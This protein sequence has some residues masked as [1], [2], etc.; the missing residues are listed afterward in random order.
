MKCRRSKNSPGAKLRG[1][2]AK[3]IRTAHPASR[4]HGGEAP[5]LPAATG[6]AAAP[7]AELR[8]EGQSEGSVR[9][10]G[11]VVVGPHGSVKGDIH[12]TAI[13]VDGEVTGDLCATTSLRI[14]PTARVTGDLQAPRVGVA[15][16]A[17]LRGSINTRGA[18]PPAADLDDQ[19]VN[20]VLSGV[21]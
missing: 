13:V 16:G 5:E 7:T 9:Y 12:A 4:R 6:T 21:S 10:A 20:Q 19:A 2:N 11:T 3:A 17:R 18:L 1:S 14:G 8:I 15:R